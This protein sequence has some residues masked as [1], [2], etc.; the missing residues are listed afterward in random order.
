MWRNKQS[1]TAAPS[2]SSGRV[3]ETSSAPK[4]LASSG[5]Q[6]GTTALA[7]SWLAPTTKVKGEISGNEDL[8]VDGKVEG[9]ISVGQHRLTVGHN[10]QVTGGLAARELIIYGK[11]EGNFSVVSESIEIKKDAS[12]IG[13]LTTR[14]IVIEDGASFKGSIE[15][16]KSD[17][18][19]DSKLDDSF[20]ART[21]AKSA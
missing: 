15:I 9:P 8:L 10:G 11:V 7:A 12:V 4:V 21:A 14:R 6:T 17:K 1:Q 3:V 19:V 20:L 5:G 13:D 2:A 18:Q 16:E